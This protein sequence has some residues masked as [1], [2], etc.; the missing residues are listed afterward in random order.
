MLTLRKGIS[1]LAATGIAMLSAT[2]SAG[3]EGSA[4]VASPPDWKV[5]YTYAASATI[6]KKDG[7]YFEFSGK[8]FREYAVFGSGMPVLYL[9]PAPVNFGGT[10]ADDSIFEGGRDWILNN[11]ETVWL[12]GV[13][14]DPNAP[15]SGPVGMPQLQLKHVVMGKRKQQQQQNPQKPQQPQRPQKPQ[16]P[17]NPQGP[18]GQEPDDSEQSPVPSFK[19]GFLNRIL[20]V[21]GEVNGLEGNKLDIT[22]ARF[23][24]LPKKFKDQDDALVEEAGYA[25]LSKTTRVYVRGDDGFE[26]VT[27]EARTKAL[28]EAERFRGKVK[29]VKPSAWEEDEDGTPVP[30]FKAKRIYITG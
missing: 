22:I 28:D 6:T 1:V 27:G 19:P 24:K 11:A 14:I 13:Y 16:K 2:A 15:G 4:P 21:R 17:Q 8:E 12:K 3:A 10:A 7:Q 25:L 18:E 29:L 26:R 9:P 20:D 5:G 30:T 23:D